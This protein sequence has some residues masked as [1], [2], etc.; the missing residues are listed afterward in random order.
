MLEPMTAANPFR[1]LSRSTVHGPGGISCAGSLYSVCFGRQPAVARPHHFRAPAGAGVQGWAAWHPVC[2]S[3]SWT[4]PPRLPSLRL[5]HRLR[6][7]PNFLGAGTGQANVV[8]DTTITGDFTCRA[9]NVDYRMDSA[10]AQAF[11]VFPANLAR[12]RH[13]A[14]AASSLPPPS[15]EA[16]AVRAEL[17]S[18]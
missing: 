8:A 11:C 3:A 6:S 5:V 18:H 7:G 2:R 16:L 10:S 14:R 1:S 13:R 12:S 9:T 4:G 17:I 15:Q